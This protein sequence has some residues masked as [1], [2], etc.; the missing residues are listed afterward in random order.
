[1]H[2]AFWPEMRRDSASPCSHEW[3]TIVIGFLEF[4]TVSVKRI[5]PCLFTVDF[6]AATEP[7]FALVGTDRGR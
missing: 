6:V 3:Q 7:V 1:M 4:N 2:C 5:L